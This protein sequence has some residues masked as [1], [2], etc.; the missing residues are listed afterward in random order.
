MRPCT[1]IAF[2]VDKRNL[3]Q[4]AVVI[5]SILEHLGPGD[6]L[7][8]HIVY[9]GEPDRSVAR[10]AGRSAGRHRIRI[11]QAQ[12]PFGVLPMF[13]HVTAAAL[14]RLQL[15]KL[16][17]DTDRVLY[18]D[19]D[20]LVLRDLRPLLA[21]ELGNSAAAAV[22]DYGLHAATH[23]ERQLGADDH[24]R[25]VREVLG[26][27]PDAYT[28]VN[29][30]L[31]LLDLATLRRENFDERATQ[32][33]LDDPGRFRWRDQDAVNLLL[34]GRIRLMDPRWNALVWHLEREERRHFAHPAERVVAALQRRDPWILHLTGSY[35]PWLRLVDLP[36]YRLWWRQA[37]RTSIRW[38]AIYLSLVLLNRRA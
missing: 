4:L 35:K 37:F 3:P 10:F 14:L 5:D 17:P 29:A 20:M 36:A 30:G 34:A 23:H 16:L 8:F 15:G 31:L 27:D 7:T 25:H 21:T 24:R 11:V 6:P 38:R 2:C 13:D 1:D 12:H 19:A 33:V 28:Y 32:L 18:L 22:V 26:W 9:D